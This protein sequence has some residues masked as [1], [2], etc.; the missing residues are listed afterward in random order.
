MSQEG[1]A[2]D[3][4]TFATELAHQDAAT[5]EAWADETLAL[6]ALASAMLQRRFPAH[7]TAWQA[8]LTHAAAEAR[9]RTDH[10]DEH[11]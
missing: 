1:P 4:H 8:R 2:V 9:R 7:W 3:A 11:Q 5:L 6:C 10:V